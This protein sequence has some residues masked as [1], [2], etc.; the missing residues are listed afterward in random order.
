MAAPGEVGSFWKVKLGQ[1][2]S[3]G[4]AITFTATTRELV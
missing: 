2:R 1:N 3:T 4:C